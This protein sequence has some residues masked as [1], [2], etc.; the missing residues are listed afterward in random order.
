[1]AMYGYAIQ[2]Y[3]DFSGYSDIAIGLA[4]LLGFTLPINFRT[5]YQSKSVTEFWRRWHISL[6]SWLKDYLYISL[7][8]NRKGKYRTYI[9]LFLTMLLGGLWHGASWKF[10]FWGMLHGTVLGIERFFNNK[11]NLPNT[12]L[13]TVLKIVLTFNFVSFAWLFFRAKDY[14][15]VLHILENIRNIEFNLSHFT[16]VIV[17]YQYVFILI[18]IGFVWH[19]LPKKLENILLSKFSEL[20]FVLKGVILG[21]IFW[22]IYLTASAETQAFIYFQF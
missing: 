10:V 4:L 5:P 20:H 15:T 11:V 21:M 1:M 14:K 3:C 13:I 6:S 17:G 2:I 22:L 8:G 18:L 16:S 9:N 19:F 7:G 12:R